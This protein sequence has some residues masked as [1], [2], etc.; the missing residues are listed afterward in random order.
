MKTT[1]I[2]NLY[3]VEPT[4]EEDMYTPYGFTGLV[5]ELEDGRIFTQNTTDVIKTYNENKD[6]L[7]PITNEDNLK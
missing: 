6:I 3:L 1:K 7:T 4:V 5:L 2:V